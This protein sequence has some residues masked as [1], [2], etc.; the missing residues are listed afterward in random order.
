MRTIHFTLNEDQ[1]N[2]YN[3]ITN[4]TQTLGV[5]PKNFF[6]RAMRMELAS[7]D[8]AEAV[9]VAAIPKPKGRPAVVIDG[10]ERKEWVAARIKAYDEAEELAAHDD[11]E[12][13]WCDTSI[14]QSMAEGCWASAEE[15]ELV[16]AYLNTMTGRKY[17]IFFPPIDE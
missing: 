17:E 16:P 14:K 11:P 13:M 15:G 7:A 4:M 3:T 2:T 1:A 5:T 8:L 12:Y 9:A 6:L 10:L